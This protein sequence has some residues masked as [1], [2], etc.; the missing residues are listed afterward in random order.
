M[1]EGVDRD[2]AKRLLHQHRIE[3]LLVVDEA[4]RCIGLITVK[5]IEK[6][7]AYPNAGKDEKGRLRVAA[8]TGVGEAGLARAEALIDAEVDVVVVDTAHGHSKG[9]LATVAQ[10]KRLSNA[11]AGDRR[12]RRHRRG[13]EGADRR[14]RRCGQGRHRAG[15]DL[16]HAHRG[17][18]RRAAADRDARRGRGMRARRTCR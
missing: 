2:E 1:N 18:R 3:K 16:H 9:V 7:Q 13:R 10:V 17:G 8:A 15:L 4:Y 12:Q 6:A 11:L 14:G 5:D